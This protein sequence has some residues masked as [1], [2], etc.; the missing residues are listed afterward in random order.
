MCP[1][2][3]TDKH[4]GLLNREERVRILPGVPTLAR[5]NTETIIHVQVK[6]DEDGN[7]LDLM[8]GVRRPGK[9]IVESWDEVIIHGPSRLLRVGKRILLHTAARVEGRNKA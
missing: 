2:G 7:V 8:C 3:V 6:R 1:R 5:G 4:T 9:P